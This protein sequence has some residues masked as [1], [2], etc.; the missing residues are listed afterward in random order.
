MFPPAVPAAVTIQP[1][2]APGC[3]DVSVEE[4]AVKLKFVSQTDETPVEVAMNSFP[5]IPLPSA[6]AGF[7]LSTLNKAIANTSIATIA[8]MVKMFCFMFV[9]IIIRPRLTGWISN[10]F[11]FWLGF[12][13]ADFIQSVPYAFFSH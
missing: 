4:V 13:L 11:F 3:V 2:N 9:I 10:F 7:D 5:A 8:P 12:E 6:G 1:A